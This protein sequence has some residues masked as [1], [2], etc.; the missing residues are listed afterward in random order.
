MCYN[1][2]IPVCVVVLGIV[3]SYMETKYLVSFH[4]VGYGI[5]L[6]AFIYSAGAIM[7][8]LDKRIEETYCGSSIVCRVMEYIGR[9]SFGIYLTHMLIKMVY[10][11]IFA[12]D[13]WFLDWAFVT[14]L[15]IS[16]IVVSRKILSSKVLK[17]IGFQ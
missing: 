5:K 11:R 7:L 17:Y 10:D 14:L 4:G 12:F 3:L 8:L 16:F 6:S 9:I 2:F 13:S 15:T 1:I